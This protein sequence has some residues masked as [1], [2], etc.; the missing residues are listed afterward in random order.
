MYSGKHNGIKQQYQLIIKK[1]MKMKKILFVLSLAVA[2]A[3]S[4]SS[5]S[6]DNDDNGKTTPEY[7]EGIIGYTAGAGNYGQN[8]GTVGSIM[9]NSLGEF[10]YSGDLYEKANGKGIGDAQD[11]LAINGLVYVTCTTSSKIEILDANGK[12]VKTITMPN[13]SPRYLATDGKYAYA[14]AY[15]GYV[16]KLDKN[17]IVDSVAV[18]PYPEAMSVADNGKLYVNLSNYTSDGNGKFIAVVDL[19]TFH[20][21]KNIECKLNPYNQSV[22]DG[23]NVYFVSYF[24]YSRNAVVQRLNTSTEKVDSLFEAPMIA[25]NPKSNSLIAMTTGYDEQWQPVTTGFF[26]YN[27]ST[28]N[29]TNYDFSAAK[30]ASQVDVDPNSGNIYVICNPSYSTPSVLYIYDSTGKLLT[31]NGIQMDYSV[32]NIRFPITGK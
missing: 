13:K 26:A 30:G 3:L 9:N 24:D 11:V 28:G 15:S 23:K 29:K 18:G 8:Q 10:I 20:K 1:E 27:L 4:F 12:I 31:P 32:Q 21:V 6:D 5:C 16:Y 2:V 25:Y 19:G 14:S 22:T 17:G 7:Q